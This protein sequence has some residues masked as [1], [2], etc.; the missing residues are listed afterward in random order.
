MRSEVDVAQLGGEVG[1]ELRL[2]LLRAQRLGGRAL[3]RTSERGR[4]RIGDADLREQRA[5]FSRLVRV[6]VS[7]RIRVRG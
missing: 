1:V 5:L 2:E 6:R 4:R 7:V 3:L